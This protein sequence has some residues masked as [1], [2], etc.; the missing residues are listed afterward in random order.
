MVKIV[1]YGSSTCSACYNLCVGLRTMRKE[2]D[3]YDAD[4]EENARI[5][6]NLGVDFLPLVQLIDD[7]CNVFWQKAGDVTLTEI[8]EAQYGTRT[9]GE[10]S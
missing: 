2:F 7:K 1:I 5:L 9:S 8:H 4:I 6:D 10:S 3:L